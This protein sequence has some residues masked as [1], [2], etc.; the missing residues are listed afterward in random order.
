MATG[1][2]YT[3][4]FENVTVATASG[5]QDL[6]YL[7]PADDKPIQILA[8]DLYVTSEVAE[9][10]EE[11]LRLRWIRGHATV[12]SGGAAA[13]ARPMR[14]ISAAAGVTARTND[15]TIASAGTAVNIWSGGL[16]VRAGGI[17]VMTPEMQF[18]CNQTDTTIVLR[19]MA[20]PADD[21]SMSGTVWFEEL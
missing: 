18:H 13:T 20:A 14:S 17:W 2:V 19:L 10:Q 7:A 11:W 1:A 21:V 4:E 6:F 3:V 5:D 16:N 15:T 12:G 8:W 9:A